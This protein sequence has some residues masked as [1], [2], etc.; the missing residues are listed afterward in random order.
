MQ[1]W[2]RRSR[3]KN[4]NTI[5]TC[6]LFE[7]AHSW[8]LS[9]ALFL[10][11]FYFHWNTH[12]RIFWLAV[13]KRLFA[14]AANVSICE[15]V[16]SFALHSHT[17]NALNWFVALVHVYALVCM[18]GIHKCV[19]VFVCMDERHSICWSCC[20]CDLN[21]APIHNIAWVGR[22][23]TFEQYYSTHNR[24]EWCTHSATT[25][26]CVLYARCINNTS[27]GLDGYILALHVNRQNSTEAPYARRHCLISCYFREF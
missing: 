24:I 4:Y 23:F 25:C 22:S 21:E 18:Y 8:W 10:S 3:K 13:V 17:F 6:M 16:V 9:L 27:L 20:V 19:R 11:I 7:N 26:L 5:K 1:N 15:S 12:V 2:R 14:F